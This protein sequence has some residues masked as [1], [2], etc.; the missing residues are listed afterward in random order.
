[1]AGGPLRQSARVFRRRRSDAPPWRSR[2]DYWRWL[3][4]RKYREF[5]S[6]GAVHSFEIVRVAVHEFGPLAVC[7]M[8]FAIDYGIEAKH[9]RERGL[10]IYVLDV[11]GDE[12]RIVWRTQI[13][14]GSSSA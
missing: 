10:E 12:P 7:E 1:M 13:P 2:T 11:S 6:V 4:G 8:T 14:R 3:H 9:L 5:G